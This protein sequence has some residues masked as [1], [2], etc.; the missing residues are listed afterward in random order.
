MS[1]TV[2]HSVAFSSALT[3]AVVKFIIP[4]RSTTDVWSFLQPL[5]L[6]V[7]ICLLAIVPVFILLCGLLDFLSS[8]L[9]NW[10]AV[11]SFAVRNILAENIGKIPATVL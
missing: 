8:G 5:S 10:T 1:Y 3:Q 11:A 7:W 4:I 2:A 9:A 6:E